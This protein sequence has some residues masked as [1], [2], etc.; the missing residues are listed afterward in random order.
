V[1]DQFS[2]AS[3]PTQTDG[4]ETCLAR[5]D[6]ISDA[7]DQLLAKLVYGAGA[8]QHDRAGDPEVMQDALERTGKVLR[9]VRFGFW[10]GRPKLAVREEVAVASDRGAGDSEDVTRRAHIGGDR[11][12]VGGDPGAC[13]TS[14]VVGGEQSVDAVAWCRREGM[15]DVESVGEAAGGY[16]QSPGIGCGADLAVVGSGDLGQGLGGL[17]H[18]CDDTGQ[19]AGF[20]GEVLR[21]AGGV[22]RADVECPV[23]VGVG[24]PPGP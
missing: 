24:E 13:R 21:G 7:E 16:E 2:G 1:V 8:R 9:I 19:V 6:A 18:G 11:G 15:R 22:R 12:D 23:G 3:G 10:R 4:F 5:L 14:L 17:M 20:G